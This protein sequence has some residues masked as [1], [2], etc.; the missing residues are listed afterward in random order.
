MAQ[1]NKSQKQVRTKE[2]WQESNRQREHEI[3]KKQER[4]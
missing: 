4:I 3:I 1:D 2:S